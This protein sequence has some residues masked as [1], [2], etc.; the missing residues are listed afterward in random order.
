M[1]KKQ[2]FIELDIDYYPDEESKDVIALFFRGLQNMSE[3]LN[4]SSDIAED[5]GNGFHWKIKITAEGRWS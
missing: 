5:G 3:A 4:I 1:K 2:E